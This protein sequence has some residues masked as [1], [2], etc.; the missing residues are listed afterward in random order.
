MPPEASASMTRSA[1]VRQGDRWLDA[2]A[3]CVLA[4]GILLFAI[5]RASLSSLASQTYR[6]PPQGVTWVSRAELHDA[7]TRWGT[8]LAIGGLILSLGAAV[9]HTAA[10][11][12]QID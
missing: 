8:G 5:G 6:P 10:K 12:R 9:K 1:T 4:A 7:Q 11:R 3:L 2:V